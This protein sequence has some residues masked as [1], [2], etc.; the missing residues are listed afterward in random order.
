MESK[1]QGLLVRNVANS[2]QKLVNDPLEGIDFMQISPMYLTKFKAA[3][4]FEIISLTLKN[5]PAVVGNGNQLGILAV[6]LLLY[7][8]SQ[9]EPSIVC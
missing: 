3:K 4:L 1:T 7:Y 5:T 2:I 6:M 8:Q 9:G